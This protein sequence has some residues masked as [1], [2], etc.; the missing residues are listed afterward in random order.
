MKQVLRINFA[1]PAQ[2][3]ERDLF[4]T[5][6]KRIWQCVRL[7]STLGTARAQ[8]LA[9]FSGRS[10][11]FVVVITCKMLCTILRQ[12]LRRFAVLNAENRNW[13]RSDDER[14]CVFGALSSFAD[15][16]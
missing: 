15:F 14:G 9:Q 10:H 6:P 12:N 1:T 8:P 7:V 4:P 2:V 3:A 11:I 16:F 5:V 13:A